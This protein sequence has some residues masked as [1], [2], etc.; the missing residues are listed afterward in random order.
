MA[1]E[2]SPINEEQKTVY[3]DERAP[4][5]FSWGEVLLVGYPIRFF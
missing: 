5:I 2:R 3:L 1:S 4:F